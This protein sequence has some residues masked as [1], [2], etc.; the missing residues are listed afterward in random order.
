[1]KIAIFSDCYLD[2]TGG[3]VT[4]IN[5]EKAELE[6]RGHTVYVFSSAYPRSS[7][8]KAKLAKSHIFPVPTCRLFG[9]GATPIAR[10][11]KIIEKW[12]LGSHPEL[13]EFDIFYVHYEAGCSIA[14]IRLARALKIP[15]I[16]VM[17]GREDMGEA[18]II[19]P[20][21]RTF[22]ALM[23]NW[24]HSWYLPHPVKVK[25]DNYLA[26]TVAR[27]KMWELMVNHANAADFVIA[28]SDYFREMLL[29]YGLSRPNTALHHGVSNALVDFPATTKDYHQGETL[30]IIWHSRLSPEKRI[31][32]F[33]EALTI[34]QSTDKP[35]TIAKATT[36]MRNLKNRTKPAP[37]YHVSIFGDGPEIVSAKSYAKL[38]RLN[39]TFHGA[40]KFDQIWEQLQ[41]SHLDVLASYDYDTF[42]MSL[43]EAE[44]AG[45]P[46]LITDP[47]LEEI[48]PPGS[49][50]LTKSPSPRAIAAGINHLLTHP[51]EIASMSQVMLRNR[52]ELKISVKI[53]KLE[54]IMHEI[55]G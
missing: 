22:V 54:R 42:G 32:P 53:D 11:P 4:T 1:M 16:Q 7:A 17:H 38:H 5:A 25:K 43:I 31:M 24:F 20:G 39:V 29:H 23:L 55:L 27:A 50:L 2:L 47:D 30:E 8:A 41:V 19:P 9:R 44:A 36:R 33:L 28:P 46:A 51:A 52:H 45:V 10:R 26:P 3:I 35:Q 49:Y 40:T 48:I 37:K 15:S 12:L 6:R 13:K 14:G 18:L 21:L 34:L